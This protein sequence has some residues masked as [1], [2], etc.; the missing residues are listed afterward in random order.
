MKNLKRILN[1]NKIDFTAI[2]IFISAIA[3]FIASMV[4]GESVNI[5]NLDSNTP[6]LQTLNNEPNVCSI[7][8]TDSCEKTQSVRF[9]KIDNVN[10]FYKFNITNFLKND[11]KLICSS[12]KD[13]E[14]HNNSPVSQSKT[15][16]SQPT[17]K[18]L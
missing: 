4:N 10:A 5:T 12:T 2:Q 13:I 18:F 16:I 3:I 7:T 17:L 14:Q 15:I 6:I 9:C 8:D 1:S 11:F